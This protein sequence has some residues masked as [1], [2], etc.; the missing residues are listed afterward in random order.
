MDLGLRDKVAL[1]SGSTKGI[2]LAIAE[3]FLAEGARVVITG[4]D[5]ARVRDTVAML[6]KESGADRVSGIEVDFTGGD[7]AVASA[8]RSAQNS[9]GVLDIV[10]ANVGGGRGLPSAEADVREWERMIGLNLISAAITARHA[11]SLLPGGAG[12]ITLVASVAGMEALPA[13]AAYIASKAAVIALGKSLSRELAGRGIRVN[14]VSPGNVLHPGGSWE[15]RMRRDPAG[16]TRYIEA[17]VPLGRFAAAAEVAAAVVFLSS[18][19]AAGFITGANLV[20]DGGQTR[21][22]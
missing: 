15:E 1:V 4:R 9:F 17:E 21:G 5:G 22:F 19:R 10:I 7:D 3:A 14:V 6:A 8:M 11:A 20:V 13:P 2:G 16:T 18:D 12:S